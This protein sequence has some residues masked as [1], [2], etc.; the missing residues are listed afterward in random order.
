MS[1]DTGKSAADLLE[2]ELK[3]VG[4]SL[5]E[6]TDISRRI[7]PKKPEGEGG[8]DAQGKGDEHQTE[9]VKVV[10]RKKGA[11][12]RKKRVKARRSYKKR[13]A[14]ARRAA[15]RYR[16]SA[17]YKKVLKLKKRL[18]PRITKLRARLG[19]RG[20]VMVTDT[21]ATG[22]LAE[23]LRSRLAEATTGTQDGGLS[24]A[25]WEALECSA[26][27]ADLAFDLA[28]RFDCLEQ[29]ETCDA[30]I[31]MAESLVDIGD[32]IEKVDDEELP[33]SLDKK[34]T[35]LVTGL[36]ESLAAYEEHWVTFDEDEDGN[37]TF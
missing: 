32:A 1:K 30:L 11:A 7:D 35:T 2:Q 6:V 17:A 24:D 29:D 13:K 34:L 4:T 20:S 18:A 14:S 15:K 3:Q 19:G 23:S 16:R 33:E 8:S 21:G 12:A 9:G 37:P 10:R 36:H 22:N 27:A 5:G 25:L 26:R 31:D 28:R